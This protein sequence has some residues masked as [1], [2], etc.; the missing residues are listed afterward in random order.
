MSTYK[1]TMPVVGYAVIEVE[2]ASEAEAIH[3]A[4][5][6]EDMDDGALRSWIAVPSLSA[7]RISVSEARAEKIE[8]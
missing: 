5:T 1:V 8:D 7:A 2:A 3:F 4:Q 6:H